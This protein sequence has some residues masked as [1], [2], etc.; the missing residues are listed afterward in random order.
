MKERDSVKFHNN[1]LLKQE[2]PNVLHFKHKQQFTTLRD[3]EA[4]ERLSRY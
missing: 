3:E 1:Q 2:K 4:A